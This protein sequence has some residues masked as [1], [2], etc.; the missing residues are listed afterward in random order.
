MK[1]TVLESEIV[2]QDD[3]KPDN[4]F[5]KGTVKVILHNKS[6]RGD[7]WNGCICNIAKEYRKR[8]VV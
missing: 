4:G 6:D 1:R 2:V 7:E 8:A 5:Y 3:F